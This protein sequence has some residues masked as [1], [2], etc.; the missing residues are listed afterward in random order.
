M[1]LY[2]ILA[3][4][5]I[6]PVIIYL[7]FIIEGVLYIKKAWKYTNDYSKQDDIIIKWISLIRNNVPNLILSLILSILLFSL[8]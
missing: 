2:L 5:S 1:S 6:I 4:I 8:K 7:S 3:I